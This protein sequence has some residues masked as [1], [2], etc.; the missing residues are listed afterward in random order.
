MKFPVE[1]RKDPKAY[2]GEVSIVKKGKKGKNREKVTL[3]MAD[4][5]LR[6]RIV[7][8]KRSARGAGRTD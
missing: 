8:D 2:Q 4:G 1:V 5:K 6:D 7:L 3:V